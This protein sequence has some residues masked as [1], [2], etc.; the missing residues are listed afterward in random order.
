MGLP[1]APLRRTG[2]TRAPVI[3]LPSSLSPWWNQLHR[4]YAE[5]AAAVQSDFVLCRRA[6]WESASN[7][8]IDA[9]RAVTWPGPSYCGATSTTS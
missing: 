4:R 7:T 8:T 9:S 1:V 2:P 6:I 3:V 5:V